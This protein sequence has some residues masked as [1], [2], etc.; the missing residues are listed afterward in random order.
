[1]DLRVWFASN[2]AEDLMTEESLSR[3]FHI[4]RT[5]ANGI[6][7]DRTKEANYFPSVRIGH[8]ARFCIGEITP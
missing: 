8:V 5:D 7:C 1:M 2:R 6:G 3:S 4:S